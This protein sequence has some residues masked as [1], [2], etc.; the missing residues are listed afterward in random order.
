MKRYLYIYL[1]VLLLTGCSV[2]SHWYNKS[3]DDPISE[4]LCTIIGKDFYYIGRT[5]FSY[6]CII[7]NNDPEV[8]SN[9][10][11]DL[12][13]IET[14]SDEKIVFTIYDEIEEGVLYPQ[15]YLSNYDIGEGNEEGY[16]RACC[17]KIFW[18]FFYDDVFLNPDTYVE[19]EG[20]KEL[21]LSQELYDSSEEKGIDWFEIWPELEHITVYDSD[22]SSII[23]ESDR[24]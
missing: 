18:E 8:L 22:D 9:F 16:E 14:D 21:T 12:I 10:V 6:E 2:A 19:I 3:P 20:I 13:S 17:L 15:L 11:N 5:E 4:V 1:L 7:R 24:P 23:S